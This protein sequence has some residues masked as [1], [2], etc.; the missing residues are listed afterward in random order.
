MRYLPRAVADGKDIEA[1][2]YM[3]LASTIAGIGFGNAYCGIVH[4]VAHACA[5]ATACHMAWPT[6]SCSRTHGVQPA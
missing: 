3:L 5:A 1:R 2:G 6:A 4:A